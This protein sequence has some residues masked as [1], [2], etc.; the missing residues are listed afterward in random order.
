MK[1]I[2]VI[3]SGCGHLDG[4]EIRESILTILSLDKRDV[5]FKAYAP[6]VEQSSVVDHSAGKEMQEKRNALTEAARIMRGDIKPLEEL[7][8]NKF[9]GLI[10]PGG[11]GVAENLTKL[12]YGKVDANINQHFKKA[13]LN[14]YEQKKPILGICI[15]PAAI[16]L[17]LKDEVRVKITLGAKNEMFSF[18]NA[19]EEVIENADS[20]CYDDKNKILSTPAYML[21]SRISNIAMGIDK[22]VSKVIELC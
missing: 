12:A 13:V 15:A 4:A 10:I 21:D 20:Y 17:C 19:E 7:D 1:K 11:Y 6:N 3:L 9:D 8:A 18:L 14:F 16:A 5:S 22:A 2:A